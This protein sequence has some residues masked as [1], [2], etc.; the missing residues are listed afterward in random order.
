LGPDGMRG[1]AAGH[2]KRFADE[3][4]R[5]LG[6]PK[7]CARVIEVLALTG[8]RLSFC[9]IAER[10]RISERSLR[11]HIGVMVARGILLRRVALT[12]TRRLAYEYHI[13]PL[14][15][16]LVLVRSELALKTSRMRTLCSELKQGRK[17]TTA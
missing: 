15:D 13:A 2:V 5:A 17:I 4:T 8:R 1:S 12:S 14:G 6:I 16:I 9:E 11:S 7:A 3:V 10:A